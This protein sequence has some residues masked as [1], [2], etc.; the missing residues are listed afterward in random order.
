LYW[1]YTFG[2]ELTSDL[3]RDAANAFK[4]RKLETSAAGLIREYLQRKL[5][6]KIGITSSINDI[7]DYEAECFTVIASE[8]ASQEE[9]DRKKRSKKPR[10][11]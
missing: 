11:R 6:S 5:L 3:K 1:K 8:I 10:K 2:G 7:T 4:G 9:K